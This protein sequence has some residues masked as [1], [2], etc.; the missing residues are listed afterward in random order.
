MQRNKMHPRIRARK[1]TSTHNSPFDDASIWSRFTFWYAVPLFRIGAQRPLVEADL[2]VIA[3]RDEIATIAH[4]IEASWTARRGSGPRA[5]ARALFFTFKAEGLWSAFFFAIDFGALIAQAAMLRP[6]VNWLETDEA[7]VAKGIMWGALLVLTGLFNAL[8]HHYA[9]FMLM[10]C[11]WNL[12]AGMTRVLH[13]KLLRVRHADVAAKFSSG[14]LYSLVAVDAQRFDNLLPFIHTSWF[15]VIAL[16]SVFVLT[17]RIVGPA[18]AAAGCGVVVASVGVQVKLAFDFRRLRA[19]TAEHTDR[20]IRL[21]GEMFAA[22]LTVKASGW[23][24]GFMHRVDQLREAETATILRSQYCKAV[25]SGLYICTVVCATFAVYAVVFIA[26]QGLPASGFRVGD[27]ASLVALL[28]VLRQII[29]FGCANFL[30]AFP[31]FLVAL[32]RMQ[33]FLDLPEAPKKASPRVASQ[34]ED[35]LLRCVDAALSWPTYDHD[36]ESRLDKRML[37]ENGESVRPWTV[38]GITFNVRVGQVVMIAGPVASGKS[39]L[40]QGAALRELDVMSG[41]VERSELLEVAYCAQQPWLFAGTLRQNVNAPNDALFDEVLHHVDLDIDVKSLPGAKEARL[42]DRGITLSGGQRARVAMA[43]AVAAA[44][45][46]SNRVLVV[47]DDPTAALDAKVSNTVVDRCFRALLATGRVAIL[48]ATHSRSLLRRADLVVVLSADGRVAAKGTFDELIAADVQVATDLLIG[49]ANDDGDD[50]DLF[51][52]TASDDDDGTHAGLPPAATENDS[53]R[54]NSTVLLLEERETGTVSLRTWLEYARGAGLS[55][56]VGVVAIFVIGQGLLV[57]SDAYLLRWSTASRRG[58]RRPRRLAIFACLTG[59]TVVVSLLRAACFYW[60]A[61][62]AATSL[63]HDALA[64]VMRAPLWW[65]TGTPRG[66]VIN[67]FSNDVGNVDELLACARV[68][69]FSRAPARGLEAQALFDLF[70]LGLLMASIVITACVAVP[71]LA[72]L[73]PF[74]WI[75]FLRFKKW[76]AKS[77]TELKRMDQILRSP[78]VSRFA[79]TLNGLVSIR[80]FDSMAESARRDLDAAL[81]VGGRAWFWWL[82]SQRL[83]G[84]YLDAMCLF[85][86][87]TLVALTIGFKVANAGK[88]AL[89]PEFLALGLLY[90]VQLASNFQWTVRQYA[91]AES[92]MASVERLLHYGRELPRE[93][94]DVGTSSPPPPQWPESARVELVDLCIRYRPDLPD[95]LH[96]ISASFPSGSTVGVAGRSGSGK[97]SL[98]LAMA[99]FNIVSRGRILL[100]GLDVTNVPLDSLREHVSIIPQDPHLFAGVLRDNVDPFR[101]KSDEEVADALRA[102]GFPANEN[103]ALLAMPVTEQAGNLSIGMRQ[104]V[105]LSRALLLRR[106]VIT[107]DEATAGIDMNLDARIQN[108]LRKATA[109]GQK[110]TVFIVAHRIWTIKDADLILVLDNGRLVELAPPSELLANPRSAFRAMYDAALAPAGDS[111]RE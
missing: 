45:A 51:V 39:S 90:T 7:R 32:K 15:A 106:E 46:S 61:M 86:L 4:R 110:S 12:R 64:G 31:E 17:A 76:T 20:R 54:R 111:S 34:D 77:M 109:L 97:S 78:A 63:H 30:M 57:A 11:G 44:L 19:K 21:I 27:V 105:C 52:V 72:V 85:F 73:V 50:D 62:R 68:V 56:F 102:V 88:N 24:A 14:K 67:R 60:C 93:G 6:L 41:R 16:I 9:F 1:S 25:T 49:V 91:L 2:P 22:V 71:F 29:S 89:E 82:L 23:T 37:L 38:S 43:R 18:A 10:R 80:T 108:M 40:L 28:N 42:G 99:R 69:K 33:H 58:Q 87:S 70:Q 5:L 75:I 8:Y 84:F 103:S 65:H 101:E 74:L 35:I 100:D 83:L 79:D 36:D 59:A 98:G 55:V 104:L 66:Q 81:D 47:L 3:G 96:D 48:V 53:D 94:G 26:N 107:L 95:V 92:F 13:D